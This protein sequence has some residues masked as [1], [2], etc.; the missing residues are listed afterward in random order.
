MDIRGWELVLF[1]LAMG[2]INYFYHY[3][4]IFIINTQRKQQ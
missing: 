2:I 3:D 1:G 4:V